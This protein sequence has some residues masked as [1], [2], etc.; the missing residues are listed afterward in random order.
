MCW[1]IIVPKLSM[2]WRGETILVSKLVSDHARSVRQD[3]ERVRV[4]G[5]ANPL[6]TSSTTASGK[7]A[8]GNHGSPA[9]ARR[10]LKSSEVSGISDSDIVAADLERF[11]STLHLNRMSGATFG[12]NGN[13]ETTQ[14]DTDNQTHYWNGSGDPLTMESAFPQSR[15]SMLLAAR[16]LPS[17]RRQVE[18]AANRIVVATHETPARRLVLRMVDLQE[19]LY[20]VNERIMSGR[21]VSEEEWT[22][23][24]KLCTNMGHVFAD[25]VR[26]EWEPLV[27]EELQRGSGS[28]VEVDPH[29][30]RL[31]EEVD[32]DGGDDNE[33][34]DEAQ[35]RRKRVILDLVDS[36]GDMYVTSYNDET[37]SVTVEL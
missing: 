15:E 10:H 14:S 19:H 20:S 7:L 21:A 33:G 16:N 3:D 25:E 37:G 22:K 8:N 34:C 28:N 12:L 5:L 6:A 23:L 9:G 30:A 24:R 27:L 11:D 13:T 36:I 35:D 29:F 26:F 17:S 2:V 32:E 4:S 1:R 31:L 18:A